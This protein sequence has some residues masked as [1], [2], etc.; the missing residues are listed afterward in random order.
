MVDVDEKKERRGGNERGAQ[1]RKGWKSKEKHWKSVAR[2][3]RRG[4]KTMQTREQQQLQRRRTTAPGWKLHLDLYALSLFLSL[5]VACRSHFLGRCR[6]PTVPFIP[7]GLSLSTSCRP[8]P[9]HRRPATWSSDITSEKLNLRLTANF[10][11]L[12]R[13][14]QIDPADFFGQ[15]II[16][17]KRDR[18]FWVANRRL[19]FLTY[20]RRWMI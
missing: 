19:T 6:P 17:F 2:D 15:R 5:S 20:W 9:F 3:R 18:I 1:R 7:F 16:L 13:S 8:V 11:R 4:V 14:S 10:L 12:F